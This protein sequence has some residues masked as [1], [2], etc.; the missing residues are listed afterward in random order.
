MFGK[1]HRAEILNLQFNAK[2]VYFWD[3]AILFLNSR[4]PSPRDIVVSFIAPRRMHLAQ[5]KDEI[6]YSVHYDVGRNRQ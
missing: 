5:N 4:L 3:I 1:D 6:L 2:E